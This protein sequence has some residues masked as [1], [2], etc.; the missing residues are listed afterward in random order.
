MAP[1][2]KWMESRYPSTRARTSTVSV[3]SKR[4]V[5]SS[6]SVSRSTSGGATTTAGGCAA[7]GAAVE[8]HQPS[9]AHASGM[10]PSTALC[11][12]ATSR[13]A[14]NQIEERR[15]DCTKVLPDRGP[16]DSA[17]YIWCHR[18]ATKARLAPAGPAIYRGQAASQD[19][20]RYRV[21]VTSEC[22]ALRAIYGRRVAVG[23]VGGAIDRWRR[24]SQ[25]VTGGRAA[26]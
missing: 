23:E 14:S 8:R 11:F 25:L 7:G 15:I 20:S 16:A 3:A 26:A 9:S 6:H 13:R 10:H 17:P 19:Q 1:S 22:V 21:C 2:R 5:Y 12:I 4:P 18:L 24:Q